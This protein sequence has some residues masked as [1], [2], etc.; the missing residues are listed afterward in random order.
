MGTGALGALF[1]CA[2]SMLTFLYRGARGLAG[3]RR[4]PR[5]PAGAQAEGG[6]VA[7]GTLR[8]GREDT[9]DVQERAVPQQPGPAWRPA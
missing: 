3:G 8:H 7:G 1:P 2:V 4:F 6:G 5:L 9:Q